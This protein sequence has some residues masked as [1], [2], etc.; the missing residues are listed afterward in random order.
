MAIVIDGSMMVVIDGSIPTMEPVQPY[1][2]VA[3]PI[4][5]LLKIL[6]YLEIRF[7]C[8]YAHFREQMNN[9]KVY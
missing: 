2:G 6:N 9:I 7:T 8:F 4:S 3:A 5:M 1:S